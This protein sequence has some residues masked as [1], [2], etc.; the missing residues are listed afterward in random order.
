MPSLPQYQQ[1]FQRLNRGNARGTKERA[2]HKPV[3]LLAL[4]DE[5]AAG[6]IRENRIYISPE[7]VA[8]FKDNWS[9]YVT[10]LHFSPDFTKPFY[11]LKGEPFWHLLPQ[12][13]REFMLTTSGSPKSFTSLQATVV[14]AWLDDDLFTLLQDALSRALLRNTLIAAYFSGIAPDHKQGYIFRVEAQMLHE[15]PVAYQQ[16]ALNFDAEELAA[17]GGIFK[18]VVPRIYNYSCCISGM[19][20]MAGT[21]AQMVD[22]CHI[23]PFAESRDDT[24][25][26]G[27][28]LCPNLH[29]AFDRGLIRIDDRY[30]VVVSP[31]FSESDSGYG[32][33]GF[34]GKRI[35][36]PAE[37]D[38]WPG[39][40]NLE[41][42]WMRWG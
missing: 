30:C 19:R 33:K 32:I 4:I 26:N 16:M 6:N 9:L 2:P 17:R 27:L 23:V 21:A 28:S 22:A 39:L 1:A 29:R 31:G 20:V 7:L 34:A 11:H 10:D 12:P 25:A 36:L 8:R 40:E 41:R 13:G 15:A 24:I 3:L 42:H 37:Q 18:R 14:C 35:A 5:I 38:Y